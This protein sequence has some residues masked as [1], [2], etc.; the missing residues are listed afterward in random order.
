MSHSDFL[1]YQ[2][3]L[4]NG[5][6]GLE[7]IYF[8]SYGFDFVNAISTMAGVFTSI[9]SPVDFKDIVNPWEGSSGLCRYKIENLKPGDI[10]G[11]SNDHVN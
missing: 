6:I 5:V 4:V 1:E 2:T 3:K 7:I 9:Q 10:I 8:G 11:K